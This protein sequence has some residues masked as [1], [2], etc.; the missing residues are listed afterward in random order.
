MPFL[1]TSS[2]SRRSIKPQRPGELLSRAY[3]AELQLAE[4][5]K[6]C[7]KTMY[8]GEQ[9][10]TKAAKAEQEG[11]RA[12]IEWLTRELRKRTRRARMRV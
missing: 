8:E 1:A 4:A 3:E 2:A 11:L 7:Y 10:L 9:L 6:Q 12:K 5:G